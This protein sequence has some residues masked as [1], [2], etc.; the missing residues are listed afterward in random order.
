MYTSRMIQLLSTGSI[1]LLWLCTSC[2]PP[3]NMV[4]RDHTRKYVQKK[5]HT[6]AGNLQHFSWEDDD[7]S[8]F[9]D[10]NE[11][12][13]V[14]RG[15]NDRYQSRPAHNNIQAAAY[16][17]GTWRSRVNKRNST[18]SHPKPSIIHPTAKHN[19]KYRVKKGDTL[20]GISRKYGISV[21]SLCKTNSISNKNRLNVGTVLMVP[22]T[23][24]GSHNKAHQGTSNKPPL[25]KWPVSPVVKYMKDGGN[26]VKSIGVYIQSRSG[27]TVR[28]SAP[29]IV[30]KTGNMRGFGNYVVLRH[31][32]RY[33][34][35]YSNLDDVFVHKGQHIPAGKV[36]G[37]MD[38]RESKLHFQINHAGK[39]ED[40]LKYLKKV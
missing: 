26:G 13:T 40:P 36:L 34:T 11:R 5:T 29:G 2:V 12:K 39:P 23:A 1:L 15:N 17:D 37:R 14:R 7:R 30:E 24:R 22:A 18:V 35:V 8:F 21:E 33:L 28:S 19:K 25:F 9:E 38:S 31:R 16:Q 6:N 20:Y 27:S 32:S 4:R 3:Q 10:N